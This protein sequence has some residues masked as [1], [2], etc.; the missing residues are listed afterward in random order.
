M[1]T[2]PTWKHRKKA[3]K[4]H[5]MLI[6]NW[7]RVFRCVD[8][9]RIDQRRRQ[10]PHTSVVRSEKCRGLRGTAW[11]KRQV[12]VGFVWLGG[13]CYTA[14]VWR[15]FL[16]L[17]Q[18]VRSIC[19]TRNQLYSY[20]HIGTADGRFGHCDQDIIGTHIWFVDLCQPDAGFTSGFGQA[21]HA[22]SFVRILSCVPTLMNACTAR[23]SCSC[24]WAALICVRIRA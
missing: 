7:L 3:A 20:M 11:H 8:A 4:R 22:G 24:V 13:S 15:G 21:L 18:R 16:P 5:N 19:K 2:M 14:R 1:Q 9:F 12:I 6:I 17:L 10:Q 23:S